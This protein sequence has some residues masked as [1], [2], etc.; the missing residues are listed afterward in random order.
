MEE[1]DDLL[2]Q[3]DDSGYLDLSHRAWSTL[4]NVLWTWGQTLIVLNISYNNI[5]SISGGLGELSLLRELDARCNQIE[6]LPEELGKCVR[7]K[8]LRI[9]GNRLRTLP[10]SLGQCRMI[11]ELYVSENQL[12]EVPPSIGSMSV[13]RVFKAANN[14]IQE[15]PPEISKCL[16]LKEIDLSGNNTRNLPSE[17]QT[18]VAMTLWLMGRE[19]KQRTNVQQLEQATAELEDSA[20]LQDEKR[21]ELEDNVNALKSERDKLEREMPHEYLRWQAKYQ[22]CKSK[23]CSIQ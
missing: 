9:N 15:T 6:S 8:V 1:F 5:N 13:L 11:E 21:I 2:Q 7:L 23:L 17:L 10:D 16:A 4:D 20:R 3:P 18:N 22:G 14:Q 12:T 19:L